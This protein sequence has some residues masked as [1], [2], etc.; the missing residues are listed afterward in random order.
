MKRN[1]SITLGEHFNEFIAN[2]MASGD[3]NN[4]SEVVR[5]GL[6]LL[7][8]HR[9]KVKLLREAILKG[10]ASGYDEN[11][12]PEEYLKQLQAEDEEELSFDP[13]SKD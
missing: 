12:D 13:R 7:E 5:D 6:R 8:E 4:A 10:E 2:E 9:M 3:Y 1:T 11:F